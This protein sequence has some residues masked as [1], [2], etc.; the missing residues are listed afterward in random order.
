MSIYWKGFG[1]LLLPFISRE[2]DHHTVFAPHTPSGTYLRSAVW[3]RQWPEPLASAQT[4]PGFGLEHQTESLQSGGKKD[5]S[6]MG[7]NVMW[8]CPLMEKETGINRQNIT[9]STRAQDT[10][11]F[12]SIWFSQPLEPC[13]AKDELVLFAITGEESETEVCPQS[14]REFELTTD[15]D[16]SFNSQFSVFSSKPV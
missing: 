3:H 4:G 11:T 9:Y 2:S 16:A 13:E 5:R 1:D 10:G 8:C 15:L 14:P 12:L 6:C 7:R